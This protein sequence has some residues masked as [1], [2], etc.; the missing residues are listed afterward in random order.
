MTSPQTVGPNFDARIR[1]AQ[2][3]GSVHDFATEVMTFYGPLAAF[4]K[5]LYDQFP[6]NTPPAQSTNAL[7]AGSTC[8]EFRVPLNL[9][10]LFAQFPDFL[11]LLQRVGPEPVARTA[12]QLSQRTPSAWGDL[13]IGYWREAGLA[14]PDG[15]DDE[16]D[17]QHATQVLTEFI[18]RAFLQPY[19]EYLASRCPAPPT[20][21][22]HT[23]CPL[24]SSGALLG[25]LRPEGDG[26]RRNLVC[27][28]CLYEWNFRRILCPYCGE[29][30]EGKLPVYV[31]VQLPHVRVEACDT[32]R[33]YLRTIDLTKDGN[34]VPVVD[35]LAS[36]PLSLWATEH[37][38]SRPHPNLLAT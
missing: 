8:A 26:G 2:L 34:A 25:V 17:E 35:D 19:A 13:L 31:A 1:R 22:A 38:Y 23:A 21:G 15:A 33:N 10:L 4:Q 9:A 5:R 7:D 12:R 20:V 28:F 27:S 36:I 29:E 14:G 6:Q 18:L 3:L 32:C 24:C 37:G 16:D 11:A 30:T